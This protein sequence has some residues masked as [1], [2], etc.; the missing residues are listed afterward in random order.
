MKCTH[1]DSKGRFGGCSVCGKH[2]PIYTHDCKRCNFIG[3]IN[4]DLSDWHDVYV[5]I[6]KEHPVLS[7]LLIRHGNEGQAYYSS[8][9]KTACNFPQ[10]I[11]NKGNIYWKAL[12]MAV[13][14]GYGQLVFDEDDNLKF[15]FIIKEK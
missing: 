2:R 6:N 8:C 5:C 12:T 14:A 7:S 11:N 15:E 9:H 4:S 10:N 13:K 3:N 1:C